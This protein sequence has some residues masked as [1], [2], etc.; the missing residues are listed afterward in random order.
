MRRS[1]KQAVLE[2][3]HIL[4]AFMSKSYIVKL[5]DGAYRITDS[6]VSL[7]S[8]VYAFLK[9]AS[10]EA[11]AQSMARWLGIWKIKRNSVST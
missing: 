8:V 11:I 5:D 9:G 4:E 3:Q 6:R 2:F 10:P 7:D 1:N